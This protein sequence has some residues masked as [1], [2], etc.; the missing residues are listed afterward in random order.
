MCDRSKRNILDY[1]GGEQ[2]FKKH[3]NLIPN[4]FGITKD[5]ISKANCGV[6]LE[7]KPLYLGVDCTN[8]TPKVKQK[9]NNIVYVGRL[10]KSKDV[11]EILSLADIFSNINFH[12]VGQG[13]LKKATTNVKFYGLLNHNELNDLFLEMD[14]HF[15]PSKSEGF[16]KVILETAAAG[17]P[18][19]VYADYGAKE[20]ISHSNNGFVINEFEQ[21]VEIVKE[22]QKNKN[23]LKENSKAAILLSEKFD[24]RIMIK[25]WENQIL[26]LK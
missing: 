19:I 23:L 24:W 15:L 11:I 14:L 6:Q 16:P 7:K 20:W 18:S 9:L 10:V 8:F 22:L 12:L 2:S 17:I 21:I 3:F 4:I 26:N 13:N 25:D 1:L 5:I